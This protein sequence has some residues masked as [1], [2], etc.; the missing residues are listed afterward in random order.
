[1]VAIT[2]NHKS[3]TTPKEEPKTTTYTHETTAPIQNLMHLDET[4]IANDLEYALFVDG[5][6]DMKLYTTILDRMPLLVAA[7][8][9]WADKAV[10]DYQNQIV[11]AIAERLRDEVANMVFDEKIDTTKK[12]MVK[13]VIDD[14]KVVETTV[15]DLMEG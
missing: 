14:E 7:T 11:P 6:L 3:D 12:V 5:E 9:R 10:R 15:T 8:R 4:D 13:T 2:N 1:M